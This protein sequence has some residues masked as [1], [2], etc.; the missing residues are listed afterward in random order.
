MLH[1]CPGPLSIGIPSPLPASSV[2]HVGQL[3]IQILLHPIVLWVRVWTAY[4]QVLGSLF[5]NEKEAYTGD[6]ERAQW[7]RVLAVL[8]GVLGSVLCIHMVANNH[9]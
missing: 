7:L 1:T 3:P 5:K 9:L 4:P 8:A 2:S 6:R